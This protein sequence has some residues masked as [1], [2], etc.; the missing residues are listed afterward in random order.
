MSSPAAAKPETARDEELARL[1]TELTEQLRKGQSPD[2]EAVAQRHPDLAGELRELWAS[3][4]LAEDLVRQTD[5]ATISRSPAP[6]LVP[7]TTPLPRTFGD[8]ELLEELGRGGMGVVY[9]A[10]QKSLGRAVALKMIL[11]GELASPI[12]L[13]RFRAEAGAAARLDHPNIV[14]VHEVGECD[15]QAFF[16]MQYVEGSTLAGQVAGGPLP[17]RQA[18][19]LM[20]TVARGVHHAHQNGILHRDL[21]PSNVLLDRQGQPHVTDFG[22]AKQVGRSARGPDRLPPDGPRS[23]L[24]ALTQSGAILGTPAY[25]APEQI[26][27]SRGLLGPASDVYSMGV[28]LYELLTGRPPFQA[29]S[30]MDTLIQVLEQDPVPPRLLNPSLDRE[31]EMICIKCLQKPAD[32]RYP[33]ALEFAEDL[34]AY[35]QGETIS[36]RPSGLAYLVGRMLRQTH[37]APVLENWGLLWMWHSLIILLLCTVTNA[38]AWEGIAG[39]LP[40][41]VL[42]SIGLVTWGSIFWA[43]RRRGGPVTFVERQI[44]HLWAGGVAGSIMLFAVEWLIGRPALE[45]SPVLAVFAGMVFLAK[46]GMLSGEFYLWAGVM[47]VTAGLMALFPMV[48]PLLFGLVSAA[49]FFIPGLKYHRQRIRTR[50]KG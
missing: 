18:A 21:K 43:L 2:L 22:L 10:W 38:M 11:R 44:A 50:R 24:H 34:D 47:F 9:K 48:G 4:L 1:L 29:A 40:Y 33:T 32:L 36:A 27:G 19:E 13:A 16:C 49:S 14:A 41:L 30:S 42:W 5:P 39:H 7:T 35:L 17:P 23:A 3:V 31:L 12:D 28:V 20:A 37:H 25:M 8:F 15:G 26:T 46:A 6:D 45:L